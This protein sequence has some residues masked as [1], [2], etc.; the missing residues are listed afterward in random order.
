MTE[1]PSYIYLALAANL[2]FAVGSQVYTHYSRKISS[3]WMNLAKA[4]VAIIPFLLIPSF[5][6]GWNSV[7]ISGILLLIL[8]GAMGLGLGD[9]FLLKGFA[10][11]GPAR[12]IML[13]SFQPVL[14]GTGAYFLFNQNIEPKKFWAILFF[15]L[16]VWV[17][18]FESY[19][20]EKNWKAYGLMLAGLG[21]VIDSVGVL[22]TRY[23]FNQNSELTSFEANVYRT[24][25]ALLF[26]VVFSFFKPIN[27]FKNFNVLETKSKLTIVLG[28]LLGTVISLTC[29]LIAIKKAHLASLGGVAITGTL[30]SAL[31]E[32]LVE[33][34]WP[35]KYLIL[36][37]LIF[38]LGMSFLI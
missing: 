28:S 15:M 12:T 6:T 9:I 30:F 31:F 33:K 8:S 23:S 4:S 34:K 21:I 17:I 20:K 14:L 35:S 27:F 22:I 26:Y 38:C 1:I 18:S 29:Y 13:F 25:G 7:S 5:F 24:S 3:V 32:C 16:C 2:S 11:L 36:A 37:F 10:E 19:K